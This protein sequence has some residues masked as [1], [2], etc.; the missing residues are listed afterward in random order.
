MKQNY[1]GRRRY[2]LLFSYLLLLFMFLN[3]SVLL[4]QNNSFI[5]R[6]TI[7]D[8]NTSESLPGASVYIPNTTTGTVTSVD[9]DF[10]LKVPEGTTLLRVRFIGYDEQELNIKKG[11]RLTVALEP[12]VNET[13]EVV[14]TAMGFRRDKKSLGY[15]ISKVDGK[16][17]TIAGVTTNP[18]EG[19]YGKAAGVGV[20]SSIAGPMGSINIKIRGAAGLESS[21]NT[22]PLFVVDG[23]PIYDKDNGMATRGYDPLN[24]FDYGSGIND[25]NPE[26][27]ESMEILKGA[28]ASVLYGSEGANGVVLITTK[29]GRKTRGLG[30]NVSYQHFWND[31]V[32]FI[33][34]Q[35]EFGSGVNQYDVNM[36]KN[37]DKSE[38]RH[39][40]VSRYNFGPRFDGKPIQFIDGKIYP[41]Q[42]YENNFINL[43]KSGSHDNVTAAISGASEKGS[44][45]LAFT[46][47][48][49]KGIMANNEQNKNVV[50]F[51]GRYKASN[52]ATFEVTSNIYSVESKNRNPN[53]QSI[54]AFGINRDYPLQEITHLYKNADGSKFSAEENDWP[55]QSYSPTYLMNFLWHQ[56]EN[57]NIDDK[58]HYIGSA[59]VNLRFTP[60]ISFIGHAGL[61][62]TDTDYTRKDPPIRLSPKVTGGSY[63]FSRRNDQ[64]VNLKGFLT[65][66]KSFFDNMFNVS[67]LVAY[68]YRENSYNSIGVSTS[69]DLQFPNFWSIDNITSWPSIGDRGRARSHSYGSRVMHSMI[70]SATLSFRDK[71]YVELQGRKDWN[72]TLPSY[73]NSYFYP[74]VAAN[75]NFINAPGDA[76]FNFAKVR[77]AWADVGRGAPGYYFLNN[78]YGAS[79]IPNT[80]AIKISSPTTLISEYIKPERKREYEIGFD[81]R[82]FNNRLE[83]NL[84]YYHSNT[85]DQISRI[86]VPQSSALKQIKFN[87]GE[88]LNYGVE[89]YL[90]GSVVKNKNMRLDLT[91]TAAIQR[92]EIKDLYNGI[93]SNPIERIGNSVIVR[94]SEGRPY[95]EI[96]MYDFARDDAGNKL[97]NNDGFYY[98]DK[99]KAMN[100]Q[101]N[102]A[103]KMLGGF[104]VDYFYKGFNV[105]V[106]IDYRLGGNI[107]S[108]SNYYLLGN[109]V[110]KQ[111]LPYRDEANGGLAYYIDQSSGKQVRI[112]WEHNKPAPAGADEGRVYHDG[113]ILP[114]KI[115]KEENGEV[116][117]GDN[118]KILSAQEYYGQYINDMNNDFFPDNLYKND[119]VKLREVAISYTFPAKW[120][121]SIGIQKL[122]LSAMG[123][124]LFYIYKSIPNIDSESTLGSNSFIENSF[125]PTTRSYGLGL[126]VS[127]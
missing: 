15:A 45:R 34:F 50:S 67:A 41:Y 111:S 125:Y 3:A 74:G 126:N 29:K 110:S 79:L 77:V 54:V 118:N 39:S 14:V 68:S 106:G 94:A 22:R 99:D 83:T 87:V 93:S 51:S 103:D 19:L 31:P 53:I 17:L 24:S 101:G 7:I 80:E 121:K 104:M 35:N 70:S 108:Y 5:V 9:G 18:V 105:H 25:I 113:V 127:F 98:L 49:Y 59:R 28:K 23:V 114:G 10:S 75:W 122:T 36:V 55:T 107:F 72:S 102:I 90:K 69:G 11:K 33:D 89:I 123:R 44:M 112:P 76:L 26:D 48:D 30:V 12:Q 64:V 88:Q 57:S 100:V 71:V 58:F 62:Y 6:G 124:N 61:D 63:R 115:A 46:K 56:N 40:V 66:N 120:S 117:Y 16:D 116:T 91:A 78:N 96:Y 1:Y 47:S 42:A 86:N 13:D 32:S 97:V 109:G 119:Y 43:F 60:H 92:S 85:Y 4:G 73:N 81:S 52:F 37:K 82:M 2:R 21:A 38:S 95:G 8:A 84:S 20:A 65:Y 27:I